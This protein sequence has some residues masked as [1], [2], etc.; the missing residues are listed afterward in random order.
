MKQEKSDGE[1][2]LFGLHI[3]T[4]SLWLPLCVMPEISDKYIYI[5]YLCCREFPT[6]I[7]VHS[8]NITN[9]RDENSQPYTIISHSTN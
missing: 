8:K 6:K 9:T 7:N 5:I 1:D 3:Y 2:I 4:S